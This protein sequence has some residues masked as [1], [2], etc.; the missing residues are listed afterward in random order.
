MNGQAA[1]AGNGAL[2]TFPKL[3]MAQAERRGEKV[4]LREKDYGIWQSWTWARSL[5]EVRSLALGLAAHG[6]ER[7]DKVAIIGDNRPYLYLAMAAAQV[8]GGVPVPIYQD[9]IAEEMFYILDHAEVRFAVA[10]D[11]E[12]VDKLLQIRDRLPHL[13]LILYHD[14]R[15]MRH[16]RMPGLERYDDVQRRGERF[17]SDH[18]DTF[19]DEVAKGTGSDLA[20]LLYTSGTTG[21]PKGVMLNYDNLIRTSYNSIDHDRLNDREEVLAYLPMAWVGDHLFSYGQ[22]MC[23]GFTVNCPES[24]ATV[25][26]DLRE[27]GPTYF[28]AP[29]RIWE[30]ILTTV[31][32]RIED[33]AAIKRRMFHYFMK[34]AT[35]VGVC[36]LDG[37]PVPLAD[38]LLYRLGGI[39]VYGPLKDN[40]GFSKIRVAYTAGE[41][42]GPEIFSFYRSLGVNIKQIYGMTEATALVCGQPDGQVYAESVGVPMPEVELRI[43]DAGEVQFRG[44]GNFIGYYKNP[45]ATA[46]TQSEDGWIA[47]GDA[48]YIDEGGHLRI[49]DRAN[50]VGKL[51]DGTM[52]APKYIENKLKF[53]PYVREAVAHG[54]GRDFVAA[55]INI[56]LEAVG[57]WAERRGLAYSGYTDLAAQL[58]VCDLIAGEIDKVNAGL[59]GDSKLAG[60]QIRRFLILHKELDPDDNELTRTRKV[61]RSFVADKYASLIDAL[62]GGADEVDV[63]AKV[64]FEDGREGTINATLRIR[65]LKPVAPLAKAS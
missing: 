11:Q 20:I 16:Y 47:S 42:I 13:E 51:V 4:F 28:F 57:N 24:G 39:L 8:L 65:D 54:S 9:S 15:G 1:G 32:V 18:P 34:V 44:P 45:Q 26:H 48:G 10:E 5:K 2:D 22:A 35:R 59:A 38:R 25:L 17:D 53:S 12:Q 36:L 55:F 40:L 63:E 27:I 19:A 61:R 30:S 64:T 52:F 50:D 62:Y 49:I 21:K 31:M 14:P 37:K 33:A 58:P 3:L 29:P 43:S 23:V 6:F 56:E 7:G 46:E 41:A 60:S